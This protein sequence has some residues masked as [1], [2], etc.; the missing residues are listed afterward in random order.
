MVGIALRDVSCASSVQHSAEA[1]EPRCHLEKDEDRTVERYL[2]KTAVPVIGD[3]ALAV[4]H[5]EDAGQGVGGMP[6]VAKRAARGMEVAE[7]SLRHMLSIRGVYML[8]LPPCLTVR[9][10]MAERTRH[11]THLPAAKSRS[12]QHHDVTRNA[13]NPSR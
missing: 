11:S 6:H 7:E 13:S 10:K 1:A 3:G 9:S 2:E 12:S 5:C 4:Q 8:K